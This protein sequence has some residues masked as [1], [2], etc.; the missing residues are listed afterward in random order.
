MGSITGNSQFRN[1]EY[2]PG[3]LKA[4]CRWGGFAAFALLLYSIGTLVQVAVI[5][6]GTPPDVAGIFDM[7]HSHKFEGL[8]RLDLPTIVAMPL[9]YVLFL[10][11]FAALRRVD[12]SNAILSS[13]LAFVGTTLVLASPTALPMLRLSE[14]YAATTNDALKE[15]YLAAGN[16]VMALNLWH[17][18]GAVLGAILLQIGAVLVCYVMLH[19]VFSRGTAWLGI[20]VHGLDL[21]HLVCGSFV[22]VTGMIMM[23]VAGVLYPFWLFLVGRKLLQIAAS[24]TVPAENSLVSAG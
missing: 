18:T 3:A 21:M 16:A 23:A 6:M 7:L 10:G 14:M 15:Q 2:G 4:L 13:S 11:L 5:G 17:N 20:I 9:Y 22:P 12:L 1:Q 24:K 19:G 8:L